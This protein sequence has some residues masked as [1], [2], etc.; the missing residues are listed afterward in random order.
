MKLST[1]TALSLHERGKRERQ[2]DAIMPQ[3]GQST[4]KE[5]CFVLCDGLGGHSHGDVAA[6]S[7]AE[8][9]YKY[10]SSVDGTVTEDCI[11]AAIASAY[12]N[13]DR[14]SEENEGYSNIGT[15]LTCICV[16]DNGFLA[17]HIG[18]SR[19]YHFRPDLP[20]ESGILY[21]SWDD[22]LVNLMVKLG[23]I[24]EEESFSHPKRNVLLKAMMPG[25]K[26][27]FPAYI[28]SS[29]EVQPGDYLFMCSD[30][31]NGFINDETL[32]SIITDST[33]SDVEKIRRIG[34]ICREQSN[35][36]YSCWLIPIIEV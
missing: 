27:R 36:N 26:T 5:R 23:E 11:K 21:R 4:E 9:V 35:D 1:G 8:S 28:H 7:V 16:T 33:L 22:S 24:T 29:E 12:D 25:P 3:C 19:I 17:A 32:F 31:V 2:E 18:D 14:L 30:G 6:K 20:A 34:D 15:T 13:L 10:I